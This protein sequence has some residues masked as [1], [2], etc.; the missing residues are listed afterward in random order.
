MTAIP[1]PFTAAD[2][3]AGETILRVATLN[4]FGRQAGWDA[5]RTV[6]INGFRELRPDIIAF[7]EAVVSDDYDQVVDVLG[8]DY[9]IVHHGGRSE[10]GTGTSLASRWPP[11]SVRE[12]D[13]HVTSRVDL[14]TRWIG[15]VV[16]V[17]ILRGSP[18]GPL[19]FAHHKPSWQWGYEHEREL[20]AAAA[21]RFIEETLDKRH[22]HVVLA[23][24]FDATP[25][26]ASVRFW[27]GKQSLD[28][29]SVCYQ[30]AWGSLHP[31][32]PGLTFTPRNPLVVD[33]EMP[34]DS[35]RRIDYIFVRCGTHGPT[36]ATR[37]CERCFDQPVDGVWAS[38]HFGVV[39]DLG[40][41]S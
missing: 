22:L 39:A 31:E 40:L 27:M 15:K 33:G 34:L 24:D 10:D 3:A 29:V 32:Q 8:E 4:L 26:S 18:M 36:L 19:L 30:D 21:A 23:G 37:R 6:L 25:D 11:G 16:V 35:G 5:R 13:L 2:P 12:L 9:F 14:S 41:P 28:G 17:E 7:Q 20:Q 38:D 1:D